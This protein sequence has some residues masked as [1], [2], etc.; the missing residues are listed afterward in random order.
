MDKMI[1]TKK[2]SSF[3]IYDTPGA[4]GTVI[5]VHG[6]TG[7]HRQLRYYQEALSPD[8]RFVSY[9]L[10][11]RG[12]SGPAAEDTSIFTHAEDLLDLIESL[13]I[14]RP[15]LMGYSMGAYICALA[16]SRLEAG[17]LV[18]LDGAGEADDD[19]RQL[20][21]PS[22]GRLKKTYP[23]PE[24]Y[25]E[26]A[27]ALYTRLNID[28]N[29]HME[30]T[31]KYEIKKEGETW[32]HKSDPVAIEQDFESFYSFI[33]EKVLPLI[34]C[35]TFLLIAEGKIGDKSPL[36]KESAY[37]K[38][39]DLLK[40]ITIRHSPANHYELVFNRQPEIIQQI[41]AFLTRKEVTS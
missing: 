18:L 5:A 21:L 20:V 19:T 11:G 1:K 30:E 15:I 6:L 41:Q 25:V 17:A 10:R 22:L 8:S 31:V 35:P 37:R 24:H 16:A 27:K 23:T 14:K 7:N 13:G 29:D 12:N 3:Q 26:E 32:R 38:T 4:Q 34:T 9:D 36:F 39:G 28:W 40:K 33:P 2:G